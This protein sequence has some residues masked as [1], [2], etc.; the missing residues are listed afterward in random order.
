[1]SVT[2]PDFVREHDIDPVTLDIIENTLSN[3]RYEM[4]RV[5]ETTAVS[6][7]I[8]E[9]SDQFP[10]IADRHG[11]MVI[12]QFGSAITT[13]LNHSPYEVGDL[14]DGDVIAL[15]DP[16][17]CEGSI[18]HTPDFLI[19]RPI[20]FAGD[21]VGYASQWGNLMDV[22][23]TA[24]GSMPITAR[25]IYYEG[26]RMPP[27][28]LYDGG[29]LNRELLALFCH[30]TRLPKQVEADIQ[31]IAAGTAAGAARVVELCERFGKDTY[32]EACDAI[33]DRTRRG[34]IDL[35]RTHLPD[36]ERFQFADHADDDGLGN[37][38]I[39]LELAMWRDG[40]RL[41]L[42]WTGTDDEVPGSVNFLLNI[43]MFKMF[44]GVFL[45]MAFAPDLVFNDGYYDLIEVTI[46]DGCVL[47][48]RF[49]APLGNRLSLMARQF[50][51]VDAVFSKALE[52][53]AVTGGYG[54]SP[55]FVYSGTDEHGNDYQILEILY[56]G[57][58]ARP[59]ADGLDGHSWWPLFKA[60]PTEYLEKYYPLRVQ[61]YEARI[62]S[63]GAGYHRGG[64]GV[65]KTYEFLADGA[66][67]YQDDRAQTYPW[68]LGGGR[69]GSPSSKTLHR[70]AD[71][72]E[73][74]LPSKVENVPVRRG[75]RL[76]FRTAGAGGL[77][78]PHTR[79]PERVAIDVRAG[80]VSVEAARDAY[81]VIVSRSGEIDADAT[82]AARAHSGG[83]T[84]ASDEFDFGPVPD[85]ARLA[86]RIAQERREFD[87]WMTAESRAGQ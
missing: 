66:I 11:R 12:G 16:Y 38:P 10:L 13:I 14:R 20:F 68:G 51:V 19:L 18:S 29:R 62:D 15:N 25:S 54:T 73:V 81:G 22:G 60:V 26:M 70:V 36:G 84:V 71:G 63:G 6:P 23:G 79:E 34:L 72:S 21:L 55:N 42:D 57:I 76:E 50:D 37:G 44:A 52:Q 48:P 5:L 32:L 74:Q 40:D 80:L 17:M 47:R 82:A 53:F 4:D 86:E 1:M 9:Q 46:P 75:D 8:R 69:H 27:L 67:S 7:V 24:P 3:T 61:R 83:S 59:F 43:E 77:G 39:K 31:A 65:A 33:L 45:I 85:R 30:N 78:D 35:I 2:E 64:H 87:A 41:H 56:G 58:P 28:K 49:P